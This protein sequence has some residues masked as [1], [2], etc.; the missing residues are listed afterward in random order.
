MHLY[1]VRGILFI[2][3]MQI[4]T[5]TSIKVSSAMTST[6]WDV[7]SVHPPTHNCAM[8]AREIIRPSHGIWASIKN[9]RGW[10]SWLR[11]LL[12]SA[13]SRLPR[14]IG[15][16]C[17]LLQC[18]SYSPPRLGTLT[19]RRR[20]SRTRIF[21][22]RKRKRKRRSAQRNAPLVLARF[23]ADHPQSDGAARVKALGR[24]K[25]GQ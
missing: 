1:N 3:K 24:V 15:C 22:W 16:T 13:P 18:P 4:H 25:D 17:A 10:G 19:G 20:R 5:W 2:M 23:S 14:S 21:P 7:V 12:E 8:Y 9:L 11:H 6:N